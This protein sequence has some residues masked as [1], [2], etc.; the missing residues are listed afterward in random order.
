MKNS[1]ATSPI[2]NFSASKAKERSIANVS[3]HGRVMQN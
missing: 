2:S 1:F 3:E